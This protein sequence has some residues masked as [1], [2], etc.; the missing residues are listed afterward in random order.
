LGGWT[1]VVHDS[2]WIRYSLHF[3]FSTNIFFSHFFSSFLLLIIFI[4]LAQ[5]KKR[6]RSPRRTGPSSHGLLAPP[7]LP[8]GDNT[9]DLI[10]QSLT[11]STL[12]RAHA[13]AFSSFAGVLLEEKV[14]APATI[15]PSLPFVAAPPPAVVPPVAPLDPPTI[16]VAP[17]VAP[18]VAAPSLPFVP[19]PHPA[20]APPVAPLDPPTMMVAPP[21]A[22]LVAVA[23]DMFHGMEPLLADDMFDVMV[24]GIVGPLDDE[25]VEPPV[26]EDCFPREVLSNS[27]H[28]TSFCNDV[29]VKPFLGKTIL[30]LCFFFEE[31]MESFYKANR[32]SLLDN[33][34]TTPNQARK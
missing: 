20:V 10:S 1:S 31:P 19:A 9:A 3:S 26:A 6:R 34:K 29:R 2:W 7:A 33:T 22:P 12:H 17:L 21:V 18:L 24:D 28:R 4:M 32:S 23:D 16:M 15:A 30:D 8:L 25:M 13:A 5:K 11:R 27:S 14:I